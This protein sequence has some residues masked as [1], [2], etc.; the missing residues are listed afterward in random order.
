[1]SLLGTFSTLAV[2]LHN[3]FRPQTTVPLPWKGMRPRAERYRASFALVHDEHG[4]EACIGCQMCQKICPSDVITV[5]AAGRRESPN[6]GKSRGWEGGF[7]LDLNA[8]IICELCIQVCP[9]DAI[10]MVREQEQPGYDRNELL[11]TRDKLYANEH[12]PLSWHSGTI[13]SDMQV[14]PKAKPAAKPAADKGEG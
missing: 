4:D 7:T 14:P 3:V 2:S 13:L 1:M 12:K 5:V 11:L 8:C 6:T 9:A 10:I